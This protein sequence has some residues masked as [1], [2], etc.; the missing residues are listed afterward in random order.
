MI[1]TSDLIVFNKV[2]ELESLTRAS[3]ALGMPKSTI[4]RKL[5]R[6]E[7]QLGTQLLRLGL[8]D[9]LRL[10]L[11][12]IVLGAGTRAFP[13]DL[14]LEATLVETRPFANGV[15]LVRYAVGT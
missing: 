11:N 7:D 15:V 1:E 8:V 2:V 12:P 10:Y 13:P 6:L 5:T 3:Q 9:E 14:S 4:S